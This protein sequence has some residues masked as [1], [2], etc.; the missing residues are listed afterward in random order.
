MY[1]AVLPTKDHKA[2]ICSVQ[3]TRE[4]EIDG[5]VTVRI[6]SSE[7]VDLAS[8]VA[9]AMWTDTHSERVGITMLDLER[10][11]LERIV[12][13]CPPGHRVEVQFAN[14]ESY[15]QAK[16]AAAGTLESEASVKW[17]RMYER[18]CER[19]RMDASG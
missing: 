15:M 12:S 7:N 6:P 16:Q 2:V 10:E 18:T 3:Q 5:Q 11:V 17:G 9:A 8:A 19:R 14:E 13:L 4:M 1:A